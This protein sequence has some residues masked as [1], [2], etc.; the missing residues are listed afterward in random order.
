MGP[1]CQS[2]ILSPTE[3]PRY[4]MG[5]NTELLYY[6]N[7]YPWNRIDCELAPKFFR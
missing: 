5:H 6:S 2:V 4:G 1:E 3:R 7:D